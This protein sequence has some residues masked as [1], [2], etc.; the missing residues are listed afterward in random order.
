M[1]TL[2]IKQDTSSQI[3]DVIDLGI[4]KVHKDAEDGEVVPVKKEGNGT[5]PTVITDVREFKSRLQ[6]SAGRQPVKHISAFEDLDSK[7]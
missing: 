5:I 1:K 6:V 2:G 4:N 3:E 7:L